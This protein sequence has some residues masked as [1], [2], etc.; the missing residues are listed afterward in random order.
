VSK[1]YVTFASFLDTSQAD[2]CHVGAMKYWLCNCSRAR[3]GI[4]YCCFV[5]TVGL[6][7]N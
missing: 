4:S 1:G 5:I 2:E 3:C 6:E 7:V